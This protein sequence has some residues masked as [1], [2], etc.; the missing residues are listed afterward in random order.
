MLWYRIELQRL[1]RFFSTRSGASCV[2]LAPLFTVVQSG[3]GRRSVLFKCLI[4]DYIC[5]CGYM[6]CLN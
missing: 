6:M 1:V 5:L 3:E 4:L 2:S